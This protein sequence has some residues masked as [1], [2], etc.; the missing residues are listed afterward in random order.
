MRSSLEQ[1]LWQ[2]VQRAHAKLRCH[3]A[4]DD[5]EFARA[6]AEWERVALADEPTLVAD[7]PGNVVPFRPSKGRK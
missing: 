2:D 3:R 5:P 7:Q 1:K 4:G 6:Y